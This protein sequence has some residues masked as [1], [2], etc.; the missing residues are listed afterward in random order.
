MRWSLCLVDLCVLIQCQPCFDDER[1]CSLLIPVHTCSHMLTAAPSP[2]VPPPPRCQGAGDGCQYR[3]Q[4]NSWH[5][6]TPGWMPG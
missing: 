5:T 1:T 3:Q 4:G 2:R 6:T